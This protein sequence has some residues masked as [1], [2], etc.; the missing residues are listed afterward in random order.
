MD[1]G[2]N[3]T[4]NYTGSATAAAVPLPADDT[5]TRLIEA[6]HLLTPSD[7]DVILRIAQGLAQREAQTQ[8]D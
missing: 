2:S 8:T 1:K 4:P 3:D 7:R 5:L 6:V